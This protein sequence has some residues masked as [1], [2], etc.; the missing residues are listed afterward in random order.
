MLM[1]GNNSVNELGLRWVTDPPI[2]VLTDQ[3]D[4]DLAVNT[5]KANLEDWKEVAVPFS[6]AASD[7]DQRDWKSPKRTKQERWN[8]RIKNTKRFSW[9]A[10]GGN[11]VVVY[12]VAGAPIGLMAMDELGGTPYVL[13][14]VTHPGSENAGA[15]LLEYA[16]QKSDEQGKGGKLK[17]MPENEECREAYL[18]LGF[19]GPPD[20]LM[21]LDPASRRDIWSKPGPKWLVTKFI[22]KKYVG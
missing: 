14:L 5:L 2:F 12:R 19:V 6:P 10:I 11:F 20:N 7:I 9:G 22:G 15:I 17:I 1:P 3:A 16:V 4:I 8:V 13:G 21:T 18:H